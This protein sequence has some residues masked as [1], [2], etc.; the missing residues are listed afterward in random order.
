MATKSSQDTTIG[1]VNGRLGQLY[2]RLLETGVTRALIY[3]SLGTYLLW[4]LFPVYWMVTGT[5][6]TRRELL[7]FPPHWIPQSITFENYVELFAAR[8][9][10]Y[11]YIYNSA[12]I[13]VGTTAI[14][15]T[16]GT[17]ATYGFVKFKYPM[18]AGEFKLPF[19]TLATRYLPP[20]VMVIPLFVMFQ[21]F[22]L[23]D[24][25]LSLILAYS[26]FSVPFVIWMM[27]GFFK[28]LPDS[29][30]EAAMLDGHTHFGAFFKIVLPLVKPGLIASTIFVLITAWNELMF[31]VV[32]TQTLDSQT[33]PVA[34]A[35]FDEQYSVQW[36]LLTVASTL[37][38]A[39]VVAFAFLVRDQLIR[40]FTMGAVK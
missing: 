16:I 38:M 39:P 10:F 15:V 34:L 17:A 35:T 24:T 25:Q 18:N 29:I 19:L 14:A 12:V 5:F 26:A 31:A 30:V 22:G 11:Y 1:Q 9:E 4:V 20:I 23:V 8:P 21:G 7:A 36:E 37:A 2:H 28:E 33:F 40:G 32:L 3:I 6:K 27:V 13:A